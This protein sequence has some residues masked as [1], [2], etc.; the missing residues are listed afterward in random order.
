M[1]TK[2]NNAEVFSDVKVFV[3]IGSSKVS[4]TVIC[5]LSDEATDGL[6]SIERTENKICPGLIEPLV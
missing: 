5:L 4:V 1:L 2:T 6:L 3:R